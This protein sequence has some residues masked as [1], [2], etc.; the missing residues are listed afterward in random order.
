MLMRSGATVSRF[1]VLWS[2]VEMRVEEDV[3]YLRVGLCDIRA[4]TLGC[5]QCAP[6]IFASVIASSNICIFIL[7]IMI[8]E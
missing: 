2:D 6:E 8:G 3:R 7:S 1:A 5:R 4:K